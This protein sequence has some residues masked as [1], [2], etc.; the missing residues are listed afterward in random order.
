MDQSNTATPDELQQAINS[1]TGSGSGSSDTSSTNDV[2]A[3]VENNLSGATE[4]IGAI[5]LGTPPTPDVPGISDAANP[6][7]PAG[8]DVPAA[9]EAPAAPAAPEIP[10]APVVSKA[11][12]G[13]EDLD[14]IKSMALSDLR[15]IIDKIDLTPEKKFKIYKEII[16]VTEDKACIEPAYN[17]AKAFANEQEKAESLLYIVEAIDK[18]GVAPKEEQ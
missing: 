3:S 9:P 4:G 11:V 10:A 12:Y 5:D 2:V 7:M 17:I 6:P 13:D 8:T 1:I 14:K 18:L 15:P 16:D